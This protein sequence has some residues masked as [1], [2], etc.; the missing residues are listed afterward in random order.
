MTFLLT[1][2]C[3]VLACCLLRNPIRKAPWLFY[4]LAVAIVVFYFAMEPI[5]FPHAIEIAMIALM[6][7]CLVPFALFVFVMYI[8]VLPK[9]SKA[10]RWVQPLRGPVSIIACI[11]VLGHMVK[12]FALYLPRVLGGTHVATN[13]MAS[14]VIAIVLFALLFVLGLT[15][16]NFV[17]NRMTT[18]TWHRIQTFAYLFYALSYIHLLIM[19]GPAA[20]KGSGSAIESIVV[21]TVVFTVYVI[22]RVLNSRGTSGEKHR[23]LATTA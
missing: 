7:K 9:G 14:F 5:G 17:K 16:F 23:E 18:K 12:Y 15:S 2:A 22:L 6:S 1:C 8:G 11:L 13:V 21:Y 3:S 10:R 20:L 19:L 4:L